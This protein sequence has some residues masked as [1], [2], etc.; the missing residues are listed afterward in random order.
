M[1]WVALSVLGLAACTQGPRE[2]VVAQGLVAD[3]APPELT[4]VDFAASGCTT[5]T[6]T[7]CRGQ[8]P[9]VLHFG[10]LAPRTLEG[11]RWSFGDGTA[12]STDE[13][14]SH[15]FAGP[16]HFS[17]ILAATA[18]G[19]SAQATKID[20]VDVDPLPIGA[21]CAD[22]ECA[23]GLTCICGDGCPG[24]PGVC[25][26]ACA[27]LCNPGTV[28]VGFAA[29]SADWQRS[30]CLP[31]CGGDS[32]CPAGVHC[33]ELPSR[34]GWAKAC[35]PGGFPVD[36]GGSCVGAS[37]AVDDPLCAAGSCADLGA[38]GLCARTCDATHP[39]PSYASCATMAGGEHR[40]LVGCS[41]SR[42]CTGDPFLACQAPDATG[43]LGFSVPGGSGTYCAPRRCQRKSDCGP[44][45]DCVVLGGASFCSQG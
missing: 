12:D 28:C 15:T 39:C 24:V 19:R 45:G 37:G 22:G 31:A 41:A 4:W 44:D 27:P 6:A 2:A 3:A 26:V 21:T 8:A 43:A 33:R 25:S 11:H 5:T 7:T 1:R 35:W 10:A 29:G 20:F 38:R 17:V 42:P 13:T 9:L 14:P 23:A 36:E 34:S 18:A 16:G 30:L 40:C 32:E